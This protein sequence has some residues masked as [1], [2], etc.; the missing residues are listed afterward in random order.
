MIGKF[1]YTKTDGGWKVKYKRPFPD[2]APYEPLCTIQG[3]Q[4]DGWTYDYHGTA[5]GPHKDRW[6][7]AHAFLDRTNRNVAVAIVEPVH[8]AWWSNPVRSD[9]RLPPWIAH[10]IYDLLVE[11]CGA[12]TYRHDRGSFI[13]ALTA[14]E[15]LGYEYR[16]NGW[17]GFGGKFWNE[18]Q[19]FRVSCY[20]EEED[21][22]TVLMVARTNERLQTLWRA[23]V[24][25]EVRQCCPH[26][27]G[28]WHGTLY[29]CNVCPRCFAEVD[30]AFLTVEV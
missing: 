8:A 28:C 30:E 2:D 14:R 22:E 18:T 29:D 1:K 10:L 9:R 12:S 27:G 11:E 6:H 4:H 24:D 21:A 3:N 5:V 23:I 15:H 16:I 13:H 25:P 7:A 20:S 26:C 17:L 19:K